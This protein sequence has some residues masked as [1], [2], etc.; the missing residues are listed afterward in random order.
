MS[1]YTSTMTDPV[2]GQDHTVE[3]DSIEEVLAKLDEFIDEEG[4]DSESGEA[5]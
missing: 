1:T 5:L 2:T 4:V 3:G